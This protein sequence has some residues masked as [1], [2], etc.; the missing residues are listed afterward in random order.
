MVSAGHVGLRLGAVC[1]LLCQVF[2]F[3]PF[4]SVWY[5][6]VTPQCR[7]LPSLATRTTSKEKVSTV[8]GAPLISGLG[9]HHGTSVERTESGKWVAECLWVKLLVFF[10]FKWRF[11][12]RTLNSM[13]V[14]L[15]SNFRDALAP[16][17]FNDIHPQ[18]ALNYLVPAELGE[19]APLSTVPLEAPLERTYVE[20]PCRAHSI[21]CQLCTQAGRSEYA[22]EQALLPLWD[23]FWRNL[24]CG[25]HCTVTCRGTQQL[26]SYLLYQGHTL[27]QSLPVS[28][29][30][31]LGRGRVHLSVEMHGLV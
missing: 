22:L 6:L 16:L 21:Q 13:P 12:V 30:V 18:A 5:S 19:F 26:I 29:R 7:R 24:T 11:W 23:S 25:S 14:R 2:H 4:C 8:E 20:M 31:G 27:F 10:S 28:K 3:S 9:A 15:G 1:N 17:S